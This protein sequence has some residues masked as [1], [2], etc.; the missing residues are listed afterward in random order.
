MMQLKNIE[1]LTAKFAESVVS[2]DLLNANPHIYSLEE[3]KEL[4]VPV[5]EKFG[6]A[7]VYL[8]GSYA[9]GK[10]HTNS[11]IDLLIEKGALKGLF[12]LSSFKLELLDVLGKKVDLVTVRDNSDKNFFA[13]INKD[14][15]IIYDDIKKSA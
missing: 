6:V 13:E 5:A 14:M 12:A 2:D 7:K 4:V 11:D 8:F 3:I 10:A 15:V 1:N 9:R